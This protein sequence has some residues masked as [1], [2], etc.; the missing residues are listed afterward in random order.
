[1]IPDTHFRPRS[2]QGIVVVVIQVRQDVRH[3]ALALVGYPTLGRGNLDRLVL[4]DVFVCGTLTMM[5]WQLDDCIKD[6]VVIFV[7]SVWIS[8]TEMQRYK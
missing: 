7:L 4:F 5:D 3:L 6:V 2:T 1:M 8:I